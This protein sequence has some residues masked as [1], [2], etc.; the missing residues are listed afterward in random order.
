VKCYVKKTLPLAPYRTFTF[1]EPPLLAPAI[2]RST[3]PKSKPSK[4]IKIDD[5]NRTISKM[6]TLARAHVSR[7]R[8]HPHP[9]ITIIDRSAVVIKKS[10]S[11]TAVTKT[12]PS[13]SKP[14]TTQSSQGMTREQEEKKKREEE[15]EAKVREEERVVKDGKRIAEMMKW[16][17]VVWSV[18]EEVPDCRRCEFCR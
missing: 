4:L 17:K 7:T 12:L 5:Y 8:S 16:G 3:Q 10:Q 6:S 11:A 13:D 2:T 15:W 18:Y 14:A 1:N 9:S